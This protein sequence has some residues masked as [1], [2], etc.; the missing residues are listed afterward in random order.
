[1]SGWIALFLLAV[2]LKE[3]LNQSLEL[4]DVSVAKFFS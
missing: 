2:G 4:L 1:M 3:R